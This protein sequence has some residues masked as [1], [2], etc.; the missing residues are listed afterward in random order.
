M[1]TLPVDPIFFP[2]PD[3]FRAWL[4]ENHAS[5]Q[6][7]WVGFWKRATG[8]PSLTWSE[9]VDQAICYGWI[10]AVRRSLG[11][12]AYAIRFTH[13]KAGS[14]W[15]A[16][17]VRKA[18][19]LMARGLMRPAGLEVFAGRDPART[20]L[21]S[22]ERERAALT[23]E[24]EAEFRANE[25]A[26]ADFQRRPPSYRKPAL[27]WIASAKQPA[28]RRRRFEQLIQC[29]EEGIPVPPMRVGKPRED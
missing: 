6:E 10:D 19:E 23:A 4:K 22:Y 2:G 13:R 12:E 18:E 29:S 16:V 7:L 14:T 24:E 8:R 3:A 15:S 21:Y 25:K 20:N 11:D 28:T 26:W 27:H 5:A 9:S 17:N 1:G